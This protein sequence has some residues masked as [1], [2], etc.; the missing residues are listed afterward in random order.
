M[1][2]KRVKSKISF[3]EIRKI[4]GARG[5]ISPVGWGGMGLLRYFCKGKEV[6]RRVLTF[7]G[8]EIF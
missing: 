3:L 2:L 7:V 6:R 8:L 5:G 4:I 1:I